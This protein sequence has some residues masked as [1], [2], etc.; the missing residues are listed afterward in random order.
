MVCKNLTLSTV[1]WTRTLVLRLTAYWNNCD[2]C[3]CCR[4][5]TVRVKHDAKESRYWSHDYHSG[6]GFLSQWHT[7]CDEELPVCTRA[8]HDLWFDVFGLYS[9]GHCEPARNSAT[10]RPHL[11]TTYHVPA[12]NITDRRAVVVPCFRHV[13]P[14]SV[15]SLRFIWA[16]S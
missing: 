5:E 14:T 4:L 1:H 9:M 11:G 12:V 16:S 7:C 15:H 3:I 8:E 13:H 2:R 10:G 6:Y